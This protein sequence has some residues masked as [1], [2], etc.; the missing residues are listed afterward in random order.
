MRRAAL[1]RNEPGVIPRRQQIPGAAAGIENMRQ[2]HSF[3]NEK[4]RSRGFAETPVAG[5]QDFQF[6]LSGDAKL[7]LGITLYDD[8]FDPLNIFSLTVNNDTIITTVSSSQLSRVWQ[9]AGA[10]AQSN[11]YLFEYF[12]YTSLLSGN[13]QLQVTWNANTAGNLLITFWYL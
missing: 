3:N 13:D 11:P 10:L 7:L 6:S 2:V 9:D 1:I 8:T 12:E 4:K 5:Q